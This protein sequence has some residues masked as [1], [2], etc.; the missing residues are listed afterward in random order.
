MYKNHKKRHAIFAIIF[1]TAVI[2]IITISFVLRGQSTQSLVN[3]NCWAI[4]N[5]GQEIEGTYGIEGVDINIVDV[6]DIGLECSNIIVG[7]VDTGIDN[8]C[9]RLTDTLW[10]N[11]GEVPNNGVDDDGNDLIDDVYGWDFYN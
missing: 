10:V 6:W 11:L 2:I 4:Y 3:S 9:A 7:V 5:Y 1:F 8:T